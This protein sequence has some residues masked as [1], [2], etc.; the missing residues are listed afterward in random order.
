MDLSCLSVP[1]WTF[2]GNVPILIEVPKKFKL[3][4]H[5]PDTHLLDKIANEEIEMYYEALETTNFYKINEIE[6]TTSDDDIEIIC[7]RCGKTVRF[8]Y[9]FTES[10]V[11]CENCINDTKNI[12]SSPRNCA[13]CAKFS[14]CCRIVTEIFYFCTICERDKGYKLRTI[15][16]R[17]F[18]LGIDSIS[19]WLPLYVDEEGNFLAQNLC[20]SSKFLNTYAIIAKGV[21]NRVEFRILSGSL[22]EIL[23]VLEKVGL[24]NNIS[25]LAD[26]YNLID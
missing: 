1:K 6:I 12:K 17:F 9:Y 7:V 20:V 11:V 18:D 24:K 4:T 5:F 10:L 23:D 25:I 26:A 14:D 19:N 21:R 16:N 2:S 22:R 13:I 8:M 15:P 3:P